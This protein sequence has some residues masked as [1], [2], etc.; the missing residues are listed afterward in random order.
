[1]SQKIFKL[2]PKINF[3]VCPDILPTFERLYVKMPENCFKILE[4]GKMSLG[5]SEKMYE[6]GP[7]SLK[8]PEIFANNA[9]HSEKGVSLF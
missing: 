9:D 5:Q 2:L 8:M 6:N 4:V 1:M 3:K 7:K